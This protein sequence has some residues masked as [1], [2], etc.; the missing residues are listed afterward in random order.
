MGIEIVTTETHK[1]VETE[2]VKSKDMN[3]SGKIAQ[4][5]QGIK[6]MTSAEDPETTTRLRELEMTAEITTQV[7]ITTQRFV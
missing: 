1:V 4:T 3:T 2:S 5:I 6:T 7:T